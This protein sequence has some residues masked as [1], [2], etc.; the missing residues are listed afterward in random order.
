MQIFSLVGPIQEVDK[1]MR[2][3]CT[4]LQKRLF[5]IRKQLDE[6]VDPMSLPSRNRGRTNQNGINIDVIKQ[7]NM[8]LDEGFSKHNPFKKDRRSV[9][10]VAMAKDST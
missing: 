9:D 1:Q 6:D 2:K 8:T 3:N 4:V 7:A 5:F 10:Q